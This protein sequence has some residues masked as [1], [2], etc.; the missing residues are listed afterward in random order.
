MSKINKELRKLNGLG[1]VRHDERLSSSILE[2]TKKYHINV[3]FVK[4]KNLLKVCTKLFCD[5]DEANDFVN[6]F[7]E[8]VYFHDG[9]KG[10]FAIVKTNEMN[11]Y[12]HLPYNKCIF[13]IEEDDTIDFDV[14]LLHEIGHIVNHTL[15]E[16]IADSYC[17]EQLNNDKRFCDWISG[18]YKSMK[19]SNPDMEWDDEYVHRYLYLND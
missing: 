18:V 16:A 6:G 4:R 17:M 7:H 12:E 15:D 9:I 2:I 3:L 5:I 10:M 14:M 13:V 8:D 11:Q 1:A 19:A